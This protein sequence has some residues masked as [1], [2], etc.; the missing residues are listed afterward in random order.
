LGEGA[1]SLGKFL[2]PLKK[3]PPEPLKI[4]P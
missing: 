1:G 2:C 3:D 4:K